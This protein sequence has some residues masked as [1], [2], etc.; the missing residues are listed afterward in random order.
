MIFNNDADV[1]GTRSSTTVINDDVSM[2]Y[3]FQRITI[4]RIERFRIFRIGEWMRR[5]KWKFGTSTLRANI[6][7]SIRSM[8]DRFSMPKNGY[9][10]RVDNCL[11]SSR[12]FIITY[13]KLIRRINYIISTGFLI[14]EIHSYFYTFRLFKLTFIF[15]NKTIFNHFNI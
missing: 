15:E 12:I 7:E 3:Q 5:E 10:I 1:K 8:R 2:R 14:T 6:W 4:R 11:G 13:N 9:L